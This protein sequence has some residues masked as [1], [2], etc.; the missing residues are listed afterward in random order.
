MTGDIFKSFGKDGS[1]SQEKEKNM[2]R[3]HFL[4]W[5]WLLFS[6]LFFNFR[7]DICLCKRYI[8]SK[9]KKED[10]ENEPDFEYN[11]FNTT[12]AF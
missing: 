9:Q 8:W 5:W 11:V 7:E 2:E 3:T 12:D 4:L 1:E 6:F 10:E